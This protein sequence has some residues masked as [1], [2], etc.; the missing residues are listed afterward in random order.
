MS[1]EISF[2]IWYLLESIF[3]VWGLIISTSILSLFSDFSEIKDFIFLSTFVSLLASVIIFFSHRKW[4]SVKSLKN[5]LYPAIPW[6]L[7][8]TYLLHI[9]QPGFLI[10]LL[11]WVLIFSSIFD[12]IFLSH[13]RSWWKYIPSYF[14]SWLLF[15]AGIIQGLFGMSGMLVAVLMKNTFSNKS[16]FRTTM[17]TF[18]IILN[19]IRL[20]Q[21]S[22]Q[23]SFDI[24]LLFSHVY[25]FL[26]VLLA[27]IIWYLIHLRISDVFFRKW[28]SFLIVVAGLKLIFS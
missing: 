6:V 10:H 27:I 26:A 2:F 9:I 11:G 7:S 16:E 23:G 21:F 22:I 28:L 25:L 1:L 19:S 24:Q 14:R 17:A 12:F 3:G 4:F 18:F 20:V 5:I 13:N 15:V 8:W